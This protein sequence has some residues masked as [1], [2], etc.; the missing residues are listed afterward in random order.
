MS[1]I[2]T[3]LHL[4]GKGFAFGA[5]L[6]LSLCLL[7]EFHSALITTVKKNTS[8]F[9]LHRSQSYVAGRLLSQK[10]RVCFTIMNDRDCSGFKA[11]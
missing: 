10:N 6:S 8:E 4:L 11:L 1:D 9:S 5:S 7:L 3:K 2:C